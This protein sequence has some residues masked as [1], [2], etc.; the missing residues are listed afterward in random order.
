VQAILELEGK[1]CVTSQSK[2]KGPFQ[3]ALFSLYDEVSDLKGETC[4]IS[5]ANDFR[6]LRLELDREIRHRFEELSKLVDMNQSNIHEHNSARL[7]EIMRRLEDECEKRQ[8]EVMSIQQELTTL[9]E[10]KLAQLSE[11]MRRLEDEREERQVEVRSI[12]QE[13]TTLAEQTRLCLQEETSHLWEALHS[14]HHDIIIEDKDNSNQVGVKSLCT[15][16]KIQP[17][18]SCK[19]SSFTRLMER[20][21][22]SKERI[23]LNVRRLVIS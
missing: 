6:T 2:L 3:A 10:S 19:S 11:I 5:T 16:R 14:H 22:I 17:H 12:H 7:S 1:Q 18:Q 13:L 15:P 23:N 21:P 8:M 9:S 20:V 4:D